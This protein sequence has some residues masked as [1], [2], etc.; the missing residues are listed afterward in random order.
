MTAPHHRLDCVTGAFGFTGRFIAHRLLERGIAVRTLT[1]HPNAGSPLAA[2]IDTRAYA[3][4]RP[5]QLAKS[6]E[7]VHTLYNTYWIRFERGGTSYD[8][9]VR[10]TRRLFEAARAAGVERVVHVSIANA[11]T[12]SDLPYYRAKGVLEHEL[13]GSGLSYAIVRPTVLFGDD[14]ILIHNIAWLL[15]RLPLF[16]VV[17]RGDYRLQPVH[18]DD[19]ARLSVELGE[20]GKNVARDAAGPEILGYHSLVEELRA[21]VGSRAWLASRA[22][23]LGLALARVLG[24]LLHDV[25]I[26]RDE[27]VGLQRDLLVSREPPAC[28]TRFSDWMHAQG[29]CAR[30]SLSLRT[31]VPLSPLCG[32]LITEERQMTLARRLWTLWFGFSRAVDRRAYAASGLALIAFKYATDA[33]LVWSV[34]G[35][36]WTPRDYL[37]PLLSIRARLVGSDHEWLLLV[38]LVWALPFVWVG[39]SMTLRRALDAGL[40]AW[41][42]LVFFVPIVNY[43]WMLLLCLLPSRESTV[44]PKAQ[45]KATASS[46]RALLSAAGPA[47][48]VGVAAMS[49]S[50]LVLDSYLG[51]L[52][53]GMPFAVGF[54]AGF[55]INRDGDRGWGPSI[56]S[57]QLALLLTAASLV[58]FALEGA[59]CLAMAFPIGAVLALMGALLGRMVAVRHNLKPSH[60]LTLLLALPLLMG[61]EAAGPAAPL[62]EVVSTVEI[63]APPDVVWPR[64]VGFA[65]L[66]PP[67]EFVFALGIAYPVSAHIEGEGVG[68]TRSCEFST[69]TFIEPITVW[70]PPRRLAFDVASQPAPMR[71]TSPYR[72]VNAPHLTNGLRSQRGE[73]RLVALPAGR[74]R[75]EGRTWYSIEMA[76]QVYWGLV[77]DHLIHTI[78]ARVL[79]HVKGLAEGGGTALR[80][81]S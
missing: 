48:V 70:D 76:P 38:L 79:A 11:D 61:V 69:G 27:L 33:L 45:L 39:A 73:F 47:A 36:L 51:M 29:D 43:L 32:A 58:L 80:G 21:A 62:R 30:P 4:D 54:I 59:L 63:D 23:F 52:F 81:G 42:G 7:G 3:F 49:V 25:L 46:V 12:G 64:V 22:G 31:G 1:N 9:A 56:A 10:N 53:V 66:P 6:L 67:R 60:V 34:T 41:S 57:A 40:S 72:H 20:R 18:V 50:V 8:I 65:E 24:L 68:A 28:E 55:R 78:H 16:A 74:T 19:L 44:T 14:A 71:E 77:S 75:L 5:E 17:G 13:A 37:N 26:T 35:T 2:R 15:R